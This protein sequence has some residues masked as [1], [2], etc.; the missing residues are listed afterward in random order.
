MGHNVTLSVCIIAVFKS[1]LYEAT[2]KNHMFQISKHV[3]LYNER[4][5]E[6]FL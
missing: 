6:F 5:T 2:S 1:L 3:L 4:Y